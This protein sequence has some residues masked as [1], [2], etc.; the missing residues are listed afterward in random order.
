LRSASASGGRRYSPVEVTEAQLKRI[1]FLDS[2]LNAFQ[3]VL[4]D[5]ARLQAKQA[6]AEIRSGRYRG[7]LHGVPI[8][9][10]DLLYMKGISTKG[11][12][13][14]LF[15]F[16][17]QYD[18]T[19]TAKLESAGA[20]VLGKLNLTEGAMGGYHRDFKVPHNPWDLNRTPGFSSS[21]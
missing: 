12:L 21:G 11:G 20:V 3:L 6:E 13:K 1:E 10:K 5:R 2:T 16:V 15:D 4:A 7:P 14:A 8:A 17:P 18:A 19:V 9:L